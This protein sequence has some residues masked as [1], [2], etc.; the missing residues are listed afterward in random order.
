MKFSQKKT[1][2]VASITGGRASAFVTD[3][4]GCPGEQTLVAMQRPSP[5]RRAPLHY[6]LLGPVAMAAEGLAVADGSGRQGGAA[7]GNPRNNFL[8]HL[9]LLNLLLGGS[10][11]GGILFRVGGSLLKIFIVICLFIE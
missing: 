6:R 7:W 4:P 3:A 2:S 10:Q 5:R 8:L 1:F 11:F 9:F